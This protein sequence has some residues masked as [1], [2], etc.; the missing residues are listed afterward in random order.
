MSGLYPIRL[1]NPGVGELELN[2]NKQNSRRLA[3]AAV[4][5]ALYAAYVFFFSVTS[6]QVLQVRI[7]DALL[8]LSILVRPL[9][10]R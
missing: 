2:K 1:T 5:A 4:I 6:F 7:V 9:L 3:L 8:P 10:E